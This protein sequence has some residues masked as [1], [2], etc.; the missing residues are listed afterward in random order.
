M[1]VREG[2]TEVQWSKIYSNKH[3]KCNI[4]KDYMYLYLLHNNDGRLVG[5][6]AESDFMK[7]AND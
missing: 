5:Y 3:K 6:L 4:S 1:E 2:N 7:A